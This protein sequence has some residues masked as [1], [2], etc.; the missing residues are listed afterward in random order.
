VRATA[1]SE[2]PALGRS[3]TVKRPQLRRKPT[4]TGVPKRAFPSRRLPREACLRLLHPCQSRV[5]A[6]TVQRSGGSKAARSTP[7][8]PR[9]TPTEGPRP[10]RLW[11]TRRTLD[12]RSAALAASV[13]ACAWPSHA[14]CGLIGPA[15]GSERPGP[16]PGTAPRSVRAPRAPRSRHAVPAGQSAPDPVGGRLPT[17]PSSPTPDHQ[18]PS[19][20]AAAALPARPGPAR[21]VM[22]I[23]LSDPLF[24][25]GVA[26][27][28]GR[29]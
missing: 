23:F 6:R 21:P 26:G 28:S 27:C 8:P 25:A 4:L 13:R 29:L 9:R 24:A 5:S 7:R 18:T 17:P 15:G 10:S 19:A 11:K 14:S 16:R 1:A 3:K 2:L 12:A 20:R 22:R